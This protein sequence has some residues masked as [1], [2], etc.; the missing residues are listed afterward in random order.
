MLLVA[1]KAGAMSRHGSGLCNTFI[2]SQMPCLYRR[3][4][5]IFKRASFSRPSGEWN[6][7]DYD[8]DYDYDVLADGVVVGRIM[9]V[10][11]APIGSPWMWTLAFGHHK[12]R[13]PT[14]AMR[15]RA[16][17]RWRRSPRAG[18]GSDNI[19]IRRNAHRATLLVGVE[20]GLDLIEPPVQH[21]TNPERQNHDQQHHFDAHADAPDPVG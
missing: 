5:D 8:Y 4:S 14:T 18:G 10:H 12:D 19:P 11:A 2:P 15:R 9:K 16:R 7:Y 1:P 20:S 17:P 6:D 21:K 13:T 3:R